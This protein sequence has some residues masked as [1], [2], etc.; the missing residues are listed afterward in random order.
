[1]VK[2]VKCDLVR[3]VFIPDDC[4]QK[5]TNEIGKASCFRYRNKK[6]ST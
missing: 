1:M 6:P 2:G 5:N 4:V 3:T